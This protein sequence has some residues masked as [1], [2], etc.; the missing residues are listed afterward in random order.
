LARRRR[1]FSGNH[2]SQRLR[3]C[4][5]RRPE[6]AAHEDGDG[7][8]YHW[9]SGKH[10]HQKDDPPHQREVVSKLVLA[11]H[12]FRSRYSLRIRGGGG[13]LRAALLQFLPDPCSKI[14]QYAVCTGTLESNQAFDN[15]LVPVEPAVT[16]S[17]HNHRIFTRHLIGKSWHCETTFDAV[18]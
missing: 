7:P 14:G 15:G 12:G 11:T 3:G 18:Q 5:L 1:R 10:R 9:Y 4:D 16:R 8:Q 6:I 2:R 17:S 13:L